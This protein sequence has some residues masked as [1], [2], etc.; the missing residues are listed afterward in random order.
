MKLL[1]R[2]GVDEY[3]QTLS[4]WI[5]IMEERN[6]AM[7]GDGGGGKSSDEEGTVRKRMSSKK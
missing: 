7:G 6:K 3:Y 1:E 2:L 5:K 4:T